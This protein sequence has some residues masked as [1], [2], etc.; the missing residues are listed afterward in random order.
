MHGLTDNYLRVEAPLIPELIN[1]IS[2]VRLGEISPL[3]PEIIT[4]FHIH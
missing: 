4:A 2:D 3:Q 1:T